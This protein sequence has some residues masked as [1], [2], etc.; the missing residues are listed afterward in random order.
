[1][2]RMSTIQVIQ[3]FRNVQVEKINDYFQ[4]EAVRR[5]VFDFLDVPDMQAIFFR[6]AKNSIEISDVPIRIPKGLIFFMVKL[7]K[8]QIS[9]NRIAEEIIYGDM[10]SD[11]LE[12]MA[13]L[14]QK[15]FQP[16]VKSKE[17]G[18]NWSEGIAK[19][20][21]DY[22]DTFVA[23]IQITQGHIR[24]VTCLP[25]PSAGSKGESLEDFDFLDQQSQQAQIH[26]LEGAIITW[27]KQIKNVLKQDP[28]SYMLKLVNPG[29]L[30]EVEFWSSK[31]QNLN[32]I[33]DQLQSERV[34]RVLKILDKSKS[35]Y[36]APFAKLC[37]EVFYARA[38]ANNVVRYLRPL[39]AWF[40][41][42]ENE[43]DFERLV[44]HFRPIM[45]LV[46]LVWKSSAYYNTPSRLVVLMRGIC[47]TLIRQAGAYLNGDTIFELIEAGE[48]VQAVRMLQTTLSVFG[49][50]KSIYF[51][52]K[53]KS[54]VDCADNPWRI[55]NNAVFVRLDAFLE[56]CHD[57]LDLAQTILQ[58][59]KLAKIE[60]G[61]TKGKTLTTSVAQIYSDFTQSVDQIRLVGK[62]ILDLDNKGFEDA[63][64]DFRSRMKELD[65]RLGSVITQGFDDTGTVGG[66]FRLLDTF[67]NLLSRPVIADQLEKKHAA[68][69][70][71]VR[72]DVEEVQAIFNRYKNE[73]PV[74]NN[75]PPIAGSL[76]W[77]RGLLERI[78]PP[79]EKL[80]NLDKKILER[81][82][83]KDAMKLYASF[84]GQL[85]DFEREN[86]EAWGRSIE[87]SSQAKLKNPLLRRLTPEEAHGGPLTL[88]VN[89]DPLLVQL[90]REVKYFLLLGLQVPSAAMEI[91]QKAEVFRRHTG[92]LD[93][94]V[95]MYNDVQTSLLPVERPL[96][97]AQLE[98]TDR[99]LSQGV[100]DGKVKT[101][102]LNWKSNGIELF[103]GESMTEARE[104][105]E[106]L[107]LLKGNLKRI[108]QIVEEWENGPVFERSPKTMLVADF[109]TL[110]KK[111]R[112]TRLQAVKESGQDIHRLLKDTNKRLKVSQGLPDWKAY[113]DFVN[114][115]V[116]CG[117]VNIMAVSVRT[118]ANQL[119]PK[120]I[121]LNNVAPML[122]IQVDLIQNDV[123]CIPRAGFVTGAT[124]ASAGVQNLVRSW[125]NGMLGL[126]QSFK[127]LD[128]S[129]GTYLRELSDAPDVQEQRAKVSVFLSRTENAAIGV[130]KIFKKFEYLWLVDVHESFASFLEDAVST[131]EVPFETD[132]E[133]TPIDGV[134]SNDAA[135]KSGDEPVQCETWTKTSINL[136]M[137]H[138][139]IQSFLVVQAEVSDCKAIYDIDFLKLNAQPVKQAISTWVT[140]WLYCYSQYL[141]NYIGTRL[142]EL[143]DFLRH[144]N[145]GLDKQI[146]NGDRD[147]L[148]AVMAIIR[149]VRKRMPEMAYV[150]E[151]LRNT[152]KLLKKHAI[153]I[154]L[155]PVGRQTAL[156][157]LEAAKMLWD[158]TVNRAF[159][160]KEEI[161]P[162]QNSMVEG[163]KKDVR[164]FE[165][166]VSKFV[167][168]FRATGPFGWTESKFHR[169]VYLQ[170]DRY[171]KQLF[172]FDE[173][174]VSLC[175]L[176]DLFELPVSKHALLS[177]VGEDI[178]TLKGLWDVVLMVE[179]LFQQ[180]KITLW[181]DIKTDDLIDE[182]KRLTKQIKVLPKK[183]REWEASKTLLAQVTNMTTLLPL[184]HELHSP[185]IRDRHWKSIMAATG[186]A[187]EKGPSFC[188]DDLIGLS[189]HRHVEV[190]LDIVDVANKEIKIE[191]RLNS[192]TD[193]WKKFE[194]KFDR[195]RDTE[196]YVLSPPDEVLEA[197]EE[198]HLQLQGMVGMGKF[199][200]FFREQVMYWQTTLGN[201]ESVLK[202]LL[203]VQRQWGSLE[204]IFLGSVDIRTQLPEDTK[205]FE[206][207][208]AEFKELMKD[209]QANPTIVV[210]CNVEGREQSL[211]NMFKELE[212][213]E[214]ALNEY[215]EVKK[216]I[217]PRFYF[218]SN[219]ALLDILSNGNNPAKIT[220]HI[221]SVFDGIGDLELC[222][223]RAQLE[224]I[225][226]EG[227]TEAKLGPLE[228]ARA[229][230]S[231]DREKV[232]FSTL[233]EM[234]GVVE[235]W[236]NDL[237]EFMRDTLKN[238]LVDSMSGAS[239]WETEK[240]RE[241]WIFMVPAQ[242]A[243][244][245]CQIIWTEE[246]ENALEELEA[247][248]DDAVKRYY[249]VCNSRL[250]ALIR[251][252][253]GSMKKN[254]RTKVIT[255]ITIDVH[256]RDVV[257][258]L[259]SK[260]VESNVDFKWQSQLRYL[261][262]AE[263]RAVHIR[264]CDF[265]TVYSFEYVG[266][267]GRLV[268]TPLT[269]R[270][271]V[272]LTTALRLTLGG[273]PA[274]P[275][276]TGKTETTKDLARGLGLPCY[277]FNCSDQMN[278]QTMADIFKGLTQVGAWGCFDEFNRIEIEVLSVV[279][280][281]VRTIL[282]AI[283]FNLIPLNREK[284]YQSLPPGAPP[285]K[286]GS[287]SFFGE[288]I[289]LIPTVG[290][291]ITMNPGYAGR[292]ELPENLK[293][294][295]RSCAM[296][297]PDLEPIA[298]NMLM[299]E[300][301]VRARPLSVKFVTLY[302]LSSELLS[303]QHHYDWG[304]RAVKSVLCVAGMLKRADPALDEEA[305]MMRALRDFN[306][307]KIPSNDTPIFLRLISDLF[308]GLDL[309][310]QIN[311]TLK[312]NCI[313]VCK[314]N[315]LQADGVFVSK[316]M[317]YQEL[318]DVRH[319]V[320]LLGP[321]GC[322]KSAVWKTLAACHNL[323]KPKPTTMYDTLNP[324][325][326]TTDELYGY[327]TLT[328]DWRDGVLSIIMRNMSKNVLPY[329]VNQ[330]QKWVVLDG[331][332]DAEWIESM[333]TVMDDNKVLTLVSN[334]RIP[335]SDA[336]RMV[337]EIHS[338]KNATPATVSRA[339]ILFINETD[340]GYQPFVDSWM[341]S[342]SSST[343]K[344]QYLLQ[345]A[346]VFDTYLRILVDEFTLQK[347]ETV[348]PLPLINMVQTL[349]R[350]FDQQSA[351][352]S[353]EKTKEVIE[354]MF[355]FCAIW[356]FGGALPSESKKT[357]AR[358]KFSNLI[359][360]IAKHTTFPD[361][362]LVFDCFIDP[363]SGETISW[364]DKVASFTSMS[365]SSATSTIVVPTSD[366]VRLTY[367]MNM[368]VM[369]GYP[370]MFVGSSGTGKTTLVG[371]Y[372]S[373]LC[374]SDE[375]YRKASINMNFY[376]DSA[377]LQAQLEQCID[378]RSGKS[379]GP[380]GAKLVY[381]IDDLNLPY[382]ETYGTQTPMALLRQHIDYG[383]WFDRSDVSLK[384]QILDCQYVT[385]MNHKSGSFF[386][387]PR[388]QRHF[389]TF[390]CQNPSDQDL[391]TIFGTIL[392]SHFFNFDSKIQSL[393]QNLTN[394]T[395]ALHNEMLVKF[396]PSAVKFHYSF[397]MRDLSFVIKGLLNARVRD[398]S[399]TLDVSKLWYHEVMRVYSDRLVSA[400]EV[401]RCRDMVVDIGKKYLE[402]DPEL[403][404]RE[405]CNFA[406]FLNKDGE[407]LGNYVVCEN[408]AKLKSSLD[409][410]LSEYNES[411]TIMNLVLFE[412]ALHHI[413]RIARILMFP[414]GNALLIGVGGS[415]KQSLSKLAAFICQYNITQLAVTGDFSVNDLK[416]NLKEMYRKAAV[417]PAEPLAFLL[418]DTQIVDERFLVYVNDLLSSGKIPD[419]FTK[420]EYDGI[421]AS[422]RNVAK[423]EGV[424][425]S[426]DSMMTYF[427]NR[428]RANLHV[429]LC[430][431]PVGELFRQR[432]RRFPGI[433]NCTTIDWFHEWPKDALVSVAQRFLEKLDINGSRAEIKDSISH[434]MALVHTSVGEASM[435][436]FEQEKRYNYTTPKSFLEL[437]E[438]YINLYK[439][440]REETF[441]NIQRLDTGLDTLQRTNRDVASL[442]E[443]LKEKKKDV[444]AK[445]AATDDLLEEMGQQ[446]SEAQAQQEVADI[447]KA[448]ADAAAAE[449]RELE[450]QAE[451]DLRIA[452]PALDAANDAVNCLDKNSLTELKSFTKPPAGVDKVTSALLIMIKD[453]RRDFSW[454]NAKKMMAKV[455][456]FKEKLEN[457]KGEDIPEDVIQR[458]QPYIDNPEFTYEK[459]RTKS[460]AAANLCNW[461]VNIV[462]FNGIYKR[463]KPLMDS[464]E[465]ATESKRRAEA[466]LAVVEEALAVIEQKLNKLQSSFMA[467]T[468]EKAKVEKEAKDCMDRLNLAERLT[469][470]LASE[471]SRWTQ[472]VENLKNSETTLPGNV[473]L[474]A[475]FTSYIGAFGAEF[476]LRLW[477]K[478][479]IQDLVSRD[480][481]IT[482]GLDPLWV[483]TS[484]S[485]A[486][487]WQNEGLPADR[488]SLENGAIL[489]NCS[490]WPLM[491]DPQLQG[492][493]WLKQHANIHAGKSGRD[494][495]MLRQGEKGWMHK[496][497]AAISAGD[498]VVLENMGETVDT[499]LEPILSKSFFRKGKN[500]YLK[501]GD[502]DIEYDIN[503]QLYLQTKLS[504]P[505]Y[506]PEIAAQCTL[507]NFIVTK[508]GLEDQLLATIVSEEEPEL[509]LTR[510]RLV[511]AFNSYKIQLK[512][513]EDTLLERLANAPEDILSD[514][515]LIEGLEAT[516]EKATEINEAVEKGKITEIGINTA[517]EVYRNVATEASLTY[518]VMLQL[519]TVDHMYQYSLDSFTKFFLKALKQAPAAPEKS[520][521][522][523]NLQ[524]TLRWVIFKWVVR[525]LFE[526]HRLI[527][528][529]QLALNLMQ[530]QSLEIGTDTGFSNEGLRFMLLGSRGGESTSSPVP[531]IPDIV[532]AGIKNLSALEG[533]EKLPKDIEENPLR[534]LE[535]FQ[536]FTPE[537][538]KLPLD[539]RELDKT[540]FKKL[541]IVRMLRP[542]RLTTALNNFIR[543]L[544]PQGKDFVECDSEL[545][546]YQILAQSFED[547]TPIIPLYFIL[548]P[549]ADIVSDV[550]KLAAKYGKTKGIDY[551]NISLGQGQDVVAQ[552][553]LD[554]GHH[555]GHWVVLNN[556]H[557]MP[558][559]LSVLEKKIEYYSQSG[560]HEEFRIM[561]S[562]DPSGS[563]P[564]S[565]LDRSIKIT[566]DPPSGLKANLKQAFACF[567]KDT[568]E[569][570]EPRTRGILFGLCQFHAVMIE[571]KK[572]GAKGYNM[573]YPFSIGDLVCSSAVLRN[574][575]ESAPAK[576]PWADLRYLFG[577]IMYGGHIVNDF[578]RLLAKTYLEFYM[579]DEL[580]DEMVMYPFADKDA[581][582]SFKAPNTAIA[583]EHIADFIDDTLKTETPLA[584]G[585]HQNAEIGFRT[586]ICE[587]LLS[588][589]LELSATDSSVSGE[590]Q[591][592][593]MIA[594]VI[595]QDILDGYREVKFDLDSILRSIEEVGPFQNVILQECERM[596]ILVD[597]IVRSLIE[598]ESGFKGDLSMTE[599]MEEL[600]NCLI[601]DKVPR[602]WEG[603]AYPSLRTLAMWLADL[604]SRLSQLNDWTANPTE[605][606]MVTWIS[607]LFNP[608]SFL[609]AVMQA[610]A[611]AN[612]YELDKLTL[613]TDVSKKLTPEEI[614]APAKDGSYI[615][616]LYLEGAS[617]NVTM[618]LIEPSKPREMY[619]QMPVVLIRP[620]INEKSDFGIFHC[621][622]YKTQQRGPTYVFS[623]QLKT[624]YDPGKW[625][626][627]GAV[628]VM[629]VI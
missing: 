405:P 604:Q 61:G 295:F 387:D 572:F 401:V 314:A 365:E 35:T 226:E 234:N 182:T 444:E 245:T 163:I 95:N 202:L 546:S 490:R 371:D 600:S 53:A 78:Q 434:H 436:Y 540:P 5:I 563:I 484:D 531:W 607:G 529:T 568:Y 538:E 376:T 394:A 139:K 384:K 118:L 590:V 599:A 270:C 312:Q 308:P 58:F 463:V 513:L 278:Y 17:V 305:V 345:L 42:M 385:C 334:E 452:K 525:G 541:L 497:I 315:N 595:I 241:E 208:D 123:V 263:E 594:E 586:Q 420:E 309:P 300:G 126:A 348:V 409:Q 266:N 204:S 450:M 574:Y 351:S 364:Q 530:T 410:L 496:I 246:V 398:Y 135:D 82:D 111:T 493:R 432:A 129:E 382:V 134:A 70:S 310:P 41:G 368:L 443:F 107:Q 33:F 64:Y 526:K 381:F 187:F 262:G 628:A 52:Y 181:A 185:S 447:E 158:N 124:S 92:N 588:T 242:I 219:A 47:N 170:I 188:L 276:G 59:S 200:D 259:I 223:S 13:S 165:T 591:S 50:F 408:P 140:K 217:F 183:A 75:L 557:L 175:E 229:M 501:I 581:V 156:E 19:E 281:Q 166:T 465:V 28:E 171:R 623:M 205:R 273:A 580:L 325:A 22:F 612:G 569:E 141:Q 288:Q 209:I 430:F 100:G 340:V 268:I 121:E 261:F 593:Q 232:V 243:L 477:K 589:I 247:G 393:T 428:A 120:Y 429:I 128:T 3:A 449:A 512:G 554:V 180:W 606:P 518:F 475:S 624:K 282:D 55:Q 467:A 462:R 25:L 173:K 533:F 481:P 539:W 131:E 521:R 260:K 626:L 608:Q 277:V 402:D 448:K 578:D 151:P 228:G 320:M 519:C 535:W 499:S 68:L 396:L 380:T 494:V 48:T 257:H 237:V 256:S 213:C 143:Y 617:W 16:L 214:K 104:I 437:I 536:H 94:I 160:V 119:N 445:K 37:K 357:D 215:L 271:Y 337:F 255:V 132:V 575:M 504:N 336:M 552:E 388:L 149:D 2:Y 69:I 327:M 144:I 26:A 23:N 74:G 559:W 613:L 265:A 555:V 383:A 11:P 97:K 324:K 285:V 168:N 619:C 567:S 329:T 423:A 508:K 71:V 548:S 328:K 551:H 453:E 148:I 528:L 279:A 56:R 350:L 400:A 96:V 29:P 442:Q 88:H 8:G 360:K 353:Q 154:D 399:T 618:S 192:I 330:T 492:I 284:M 196:V 317:Q 601:F 101:K 46:L 456:A 404:Y 482:E 331:D 49:K 63:F 576:V 379:Y 193:A 323:G 621:P 122:E 625:V 44:Y 407:D 127:R 115:V 174:A 302:R 534:F 343:E 264:I 523:S 294:L 367:L 306:T 338:L 106:V 358:V 495:H 177:E 108:E 197:L 344:S 561:L 231:K 406:H 4:G 51:D 40:E 361:N 117:L 471:N 322:G 283:S 292:T 90:L 114:N 21:R 374:V 201:I 130:C 72:S 417:K 553:R 362:A 225:K 186:T 326:V 45:H 500:L 80:K 62:G 441:A 392:N 34:R 102:G 470:G 342:K 14:T 133:E 169:D 161:Q 412:Q 83:T 293:A 516:K 524:F 39:I 194:L 38:E 454:E 287:F 291:F 303:K 43:M 252:V 298:E 172:V 179:S 473:M 206:S 142:I 585:L 212:K 286:V 321:A 579:R 138:E 178:K 346:E 426:R 239:L 510:N 150:F 520:A 390:M 76:T 66:K 73:P 577:E 319:S 421:F 159:R 615:T 433:I 431:S 389:A 240:P 532:W 556:V 18:Q 280:T 418:T 560:T 460:A 414:G 91:Y 509:E 622:V 485:E 355:L 487:E 472:T 491:I 195:H 190:V 596:N 549:G 116:V 93:L 427:I 304:L 505:H 15:I 435:E 290:F 253:Q 233:F 349:C 483:L 254:D 502:E 269:D 476:R 189:L 238:S 611:Q 299:A 558:R 86:I 603:L 99:A 152:V 550:D 103:I 614:T 498:T 352:F 609:T 162:L 378:K 249:D 24:G 587:T 620:A 457:Y 77:C 31:A 373:S 479:W 592:G 506:K 251:L 250:E 564:V 218:V 89:F 627:A 318:L 605:T 386:V 459:M 347:M 113:V 224:T 598:L 366:T 602:T 422:L 584:F 363:Y 125:I 511:A 272:T 36:N 30:S 157:F 147:A 110:Q 235:N 573:M 507:I 544:L 464:L 391:N 413:T 466:D 570:L 57:I 220:P 597:E 274:G 527:F 629:D 146:E 87:A 610:T 411:H 356:S 469:S 84:L 81:D 468:E 370:V 616:G 54:S 571:R 32:G 339:G 136:D 369:G 289:S 375:T 236:L 275:A 311:S 335:L 191:A 98:R 397:T 458:V 440:R 503:F 67:D 582:D 244:V 425:D 137:F 211:T 316:V 395:I 297:R 332:I 547:S 333:N 221:G 1:M 222:M 301:F 198:Q 562:S 455:D 416:E 480:I 488:I 7:S 451:G 439:K 424:P 112:Q 20:V 543:D 85:A 307:P 210:C 542:D 207:V 403:I 354:R 415:G 514:I 9:E 566:S 438:F 79:L 105:T 65:R 515:P 267:C 583:Y 153:A 10:S 446:R 203:T 27:T 537:S 230:I 176:E 545:S 517:R 419:L 60:V 461:V 296:I 167:N 199:V 489:T 478:E 155:P 12:H 377:A 359:K 372:L 227:M 565:I 216:S 522:V 248:Q 164:A 341:K 258:A 474:A 145:D 313:E 486:A 109:V 6:D 184:V